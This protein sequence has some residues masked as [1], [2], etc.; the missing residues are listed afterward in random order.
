MLPMTVMGKVDRGAVIAEV[1]DRIK[2]LMQ[3]GTSEETS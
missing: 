3:G 2:E 1:D